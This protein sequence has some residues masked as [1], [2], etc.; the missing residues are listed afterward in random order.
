MP[1]PNSESHIR[2]GKVPLNVVA[3]W[4]LWDE[5]A[6]GTS[7]RARARTTVILTDEEFGRSL[8]S[9][10]Y[11]DRGARARRQAPRQLR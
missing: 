1:V 11:G 3:P 8:V 2:I 7:N 10:R 6:R 9:E 4:V 5:V